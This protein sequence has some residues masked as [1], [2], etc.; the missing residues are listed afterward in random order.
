MCREGPCMWNSCL[1]DFLS[2]S[3]ARKRSK[4]SA[5]QCYLH[6]VQKES[7][8]KKGNGSKQFDHF[9]MCHLTQAS[10]ESVASVMWLKAIALSSGRQE[11]AEQTIEITR[12]WWAFHWQTILLADSRL[13]ELGNR[14]L[15]SK[16]F[17]INK[18]ALN[19]FRVCLVPHESPFSTE[20]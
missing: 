11:L 6:S 7:A 1:T 19:A 12:A 4:A 16:S 8:L 9:F 17:L 18:S 2:G 3:S 5:F 15:D 20:K 14:G 10:T 13:N